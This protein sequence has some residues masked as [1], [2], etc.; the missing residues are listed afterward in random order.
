MDEEQAA[1]LIKELERI[2]FLLRNGK[3]QAFTSI[4][5]SGEHKR[6]QQILVVPED[7]LVRMIGYLTVHL[8]DV[9]SM[10]PAPATGEEEFGERS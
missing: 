8:R 6:I 7:K 5:L 4:Y 1:G 3:I 10:V 2:I 9:V